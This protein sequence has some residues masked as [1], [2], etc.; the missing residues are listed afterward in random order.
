MR[1]HH[2]VHASSNAEAKRLDL[3]AALSAHEAVP[4]FTDR[5]GDRPQVLACLDYLRAATLRQSTGLQA[6]ARPQAACFRKRSRRSGDETPHIPRDMRRWNSSRT[7]G[8]QRLAR[9]VQCRGM[10]R[11]FA[12]AI[13]DRLIW[14]T[15]KWP[16]RARGAPFD[17][18]VGRAG[19][20]E[21][22]KTTSVTCRKA[23]PY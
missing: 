11:D 22:G 19:F 13:L 16:R 17:S 4:V 20:T 1:K 21:S 15:R 14:E 2:R 3:E 6:S 7:R 8:S 5:V 18:R 10:E 23:W 9:V 12:V